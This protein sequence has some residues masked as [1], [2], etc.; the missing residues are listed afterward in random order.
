MRRSFWILIIFFTIPYYYIIE[1]NFNAFF[2]QGVPYGWDR[3][4]VALFLVLEIFPIIFKVEKC[5][6]F[7]T[8]WNKKKIQKAY[9]WL[10]FQIFDTL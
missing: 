10:I 2:V 7:D 1:I 4:T 8:I 6:H 5:V 3:F 9:D